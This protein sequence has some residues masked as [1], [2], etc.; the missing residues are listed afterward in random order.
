MSHQHN[1]ATY[2]YVRRCPPYKKIDNASY[3]HLLRD[4]FIMTDNTLY[5]VSY[6]VLITNMRQRN[7][8]API[9]IFTDVP[10]TDISITKIADADADTDIYFMLQSSQIY[11]LNAY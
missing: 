3:A 9:W 5:A 8:G 2:V 4:N 6:L 11:L 7:R 10:I 1:N